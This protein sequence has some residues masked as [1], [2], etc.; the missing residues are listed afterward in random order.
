MVRHSVRVREIRG[1]NPRSPTRGVMFKFLDN[2]RIR[3]FQ[4]PILNKIQSKTWMILTLLVWAAISLYFYNWQDVFG[5]I[6]VASFFAV[7]LDF[8]IL[9]FFKQKSY[10]PDAAL[11]SALIISLVLPPQSSMLT[12][13]TAVSVAILSKHLIKIKGRHIFNPANLG[14]LVSIILFQSYDSW[15]A[16]T[17]LWALIILGLGIVFM[18]DK[19]EQLFS[20]FLVYFGIL[21]LGKFLQG[22]SGA[23][24]SIFLENYGLYFFAFIML[25]EPLTSP[26]S[27]KL[28]QGIFGAQVGLLSALLYL[29]QIAPYLILALFLADLSVPFLNRLKS[30]TEV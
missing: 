25:I 22:Q 2:L 11:I 29:F 20:F 13:V 5:Q 30:K 10:F 23:I 8:L 16:A 12:I 24:S 9:K 14:I 1:S 21:I 17:F 26:I 27:S 19:F 18:Q 15:W 6:L 4:L 3:I 7:I 28:A